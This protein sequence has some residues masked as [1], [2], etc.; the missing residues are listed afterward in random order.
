[1]TLR[2][3]LILSLA[4]AALT[5]ACA[6]VGDV[7]SN[8]AVDDADDVAISSTAT[9]T[10]APTT[11]APTTTEPT[12]TTTAPT[13][14]APPTTIDP[15]VV[16][17]ESMTI[18]QKVGQMFM[19]LFGGT[20]AGNP[21]DPN[22]PAGFVATYQLGGV[23]YLGPN[24]TGADQTRA[25][26]EQ[27]QAAG[28][29][30]IGLL[31]AVDQ[32]GGRVARVSDEVTAMPS[33]RTLASAG[34]EAVEAASAR[35]A[36]ELAA[37]GINFVLAPVADLTDSNAGVI[38]NRSYSSDPGIASAMVSAAVRGLQSNGVGAVV[39]HW[40]GHG[41]TTVDSHQSLPTIDVSEEVWRERERVPFAGAIDESVAGVMIGHLAFPALDP[42]GEPAT[43][44]LV[45]IDEL[46]RNDL[47]F[48]G[49]VI[50]DAL[51][52]GAVSGQDRAELAVRSVEAGVDILL[53]PPDLLAARSGVLDAVASGRISE[54]RIDESVLRI[55]R[56]K[57]RLGL[58]S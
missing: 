9:T 10:T 16:L 51:D 44:S 11:T 40:P 45:L 35:S 41:D 17:I 23:I 14:T 22:T 32:E 52:M 21:A 8:A 38:G 53:A 47:G 42:S 39:K 2:P 13:T 48:E 57:D 46:L 33:A 34:E 3:I 27:L 58:L 31:I 28:P 36:T 55:L 43:V 19:P 7:R 18:E 1:M 15:L 24:I 49:I 26:S 5:A 54:E 29:D 6:G 20:Q 12:T 56:E 4:L 30:G 50:T 37:Q 25:F